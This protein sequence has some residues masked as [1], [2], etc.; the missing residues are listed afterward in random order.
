MPSQVRLSFH[1]PTSV[2]DRA[3]V[4]VVVPVASGVGDGRSAA[5]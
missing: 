5:S 3:G 2:L 4:L 1:L